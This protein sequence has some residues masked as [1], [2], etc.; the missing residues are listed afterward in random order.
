MKFAIITHVQHIK[1]DNQYFGYA[2][3]VREMNIWFKY[4]DEVIVVAPMVSELL[5]PIHSSY[6]ATSINFKRVPEFSIT[7]VLQLLKTL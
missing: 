6:V 4:V 1:G 7:S 3:Y 2:P 5:N